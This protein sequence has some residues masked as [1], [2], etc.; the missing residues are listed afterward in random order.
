TLFSNV[1]GATWVAPGLAVAAGAGVGLA[2]TGV[3]LAATAVALADAAGLAAGVDVHAAMSSASHAARAPTIINARRRPPRPTP[4]APPP[5]PAA[6]RVASMPFCAVGVGHCS[7]ARNRELNV[8]RPP[9]I[10]RRSVA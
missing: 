7:S 4:G 3:G 8:P 6:A 9:V 2:A 10:D 5:A 1:P